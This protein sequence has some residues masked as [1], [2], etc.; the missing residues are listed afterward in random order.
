MRTK[1]HVFHCFKE[2]NDILDNQTNMK[3]NIFILFSFKTFVMIMELKHK[4]NI[5]TPQHNGIVEW[6]NGTLMERVRTILSR[7]SLEDKLWVEVVCITCYV[8]KRSP[9]SPLT[10]KTH[11]EDW[12]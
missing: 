1:L 5:Y 7:A 2:F 8:I 9:L 6:M 3:F 4:R 10:D 11:M 12:I